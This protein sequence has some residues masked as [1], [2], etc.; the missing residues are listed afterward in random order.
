MTTTDDRKEV[1]DFIDVYFDG[2]QSLLVH[3]DS[4]INGVDDLTSEHT[5]IGIKGATSVQNLREVNPAPEV[6]ELENYSEGFV[7]LQSGQ[8]DTLTTD[9][10]MLLGMIE[11]DPNYRIAGE[12]FVG[13]PYGIGVNKGQE[14]FLKQINE[15]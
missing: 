5:V 7:A 15:A 2:G 11:Q 12:N 13:E 10:A 1:V 4:D 9:S 14:A 3:E 6:I 8:G